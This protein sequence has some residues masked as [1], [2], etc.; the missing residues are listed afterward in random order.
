MAR[1]ARHAHA[2]V[3]RTREHTHIRAYTRARARTRMHGFDQIHKIHKSTK[4]AYLFDFA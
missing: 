1:S 3:T 2:R 4:R